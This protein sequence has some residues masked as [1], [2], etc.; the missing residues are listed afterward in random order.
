MNTTTYRETRHRP[1]SIFRRQYEFCSRRTTTAPPTQG[2][3]CSTRSGREHGLLRALLR[4]HSKQL[5]AKLVQ[6]PCRAGQNVFFN[7]GARTS[8]SHHNKTSSLVS[9]KTC[10]G[11]VDVSRCCVQV[12]V[13]RHIWLIGGMATHLPLFRA[14]MYL[15][16]PF[17]HEKRVLSSP[18]GQREVDAG[19]IR[20]RYVDAVAMA[21]AVVTCRRCGHRS[22]YMKTCY[23]ISMPSEFPIGRTK[24]EKKGNL[25]LRVVVDTRFLLGSG[26]QEAPAISKKRR[27]LGGERLDFLL[28]C[29]YL[30]HKVTLG[31]ELGC[32]TA[33]DPE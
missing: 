22:I 33:P 24:Y 4:D 7:L 21:G 9:V 25:L 5:I 30:V 14:G 8:V 19:E 20:Y 3:S 32:S 13:C 17:F 31:C 16:R 29:R 2:L 26:I 11:N 27:F 6:E 15:G 18:H 10:R 12:S 23:G 28:C 1:P